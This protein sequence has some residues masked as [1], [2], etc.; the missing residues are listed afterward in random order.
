MAYSLKSKSDS[1]DLDSERIFFSDLSEEAQQKALDKKGISDYRDANWD[2]IPIVY[3][4]E[5]ISNL[6]QDEI[7]D[8]ALAFV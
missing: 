3:Y 1:R 4:Y 2:I 7:D 8:N 5:P 6:S